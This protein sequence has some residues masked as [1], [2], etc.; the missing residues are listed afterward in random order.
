MMPIGN[1]TVAIGISIRSTARMIEM[2]ALN[3]FAAGAAERVIAANIGRSRTH[4][5][6]DTVFTLL[7]HD[8]ATVFPT[9][10]DGIQAWSLR[11]GDRDG[12]L[13]VTPEKN[14]LEAIRDALGIPKLRVVPTGGDAFQAQREQ[15]D[16]GNNMVAL[17]PGVVVAYTRTPY[18]NQKVREQGVEVIEIEGSELGKG[19]GG[20]HCMTCPLLCDPA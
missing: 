6:L 12:T 7:D 2:V 14:F 18:T 11:P 4:T 13:H 10:V 20:G 17:R 5:H 1:K 3:L 19:R 9:V 16:N 8:A 15:W